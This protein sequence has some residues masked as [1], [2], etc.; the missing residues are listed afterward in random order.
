MNPTAVEHLFRVACGLYAASLLAYLAALAKDRKTV[1]RL[2]TGLAGAGFVAHTVWIVVRWYL[3]A[4]VEVGAAQAVGHGVGWGAA[5]LA[6][7]PLTNLYESLVVTAWCVVGIYLVFE[8]RWS[9]RPVGV[10][11]LGVGLA[12]MAEAY[13]VTEKELRPLAP[14]LQSWWLASHVIVLFAAYA[15]FLVAAALAFL[16]LLKAG[17][18]MAA[19][20]V[21][22]AVAVGA[23]LAALG[24]VHGLAHGDFE[25]RGGGGAP[26]KVG[27]AGP[28]LAATIACFVLAA[29]FWALDLRMRR[30]SGRGLLA[31]E[32]GIASLLATCSVPFLVARPFASS[33]KGNYALGLVLVALV[34]STAFVALASWREQVLSRLPERVVLDDLTHRAILVGLPLLGL[35]IVMGAFWAYDAWGTYWSW[36]PKEI[37]SLVSFLVYTLY[38]HTRRTL[39]WTGRRTAVIAIVGFALVVFTY[40]GVN[41]G[42]TGDGLHTYGNG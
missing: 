19:M 8:R 38:L 7:P 22:V 1:G 3:A 35:G 6:H 41:L 36:D 15:L 18:P 17:T 2:A 42:L 37:W 39:G 31:L 10:I 9:L 29:A 21:V 30:S 4:A 13:L 25:L 26:V 16:S 23:I 11:V 5:L 40:L 33:L 28:L 24:F 20:G 14:A 32:A 27:A 12:A 34:V